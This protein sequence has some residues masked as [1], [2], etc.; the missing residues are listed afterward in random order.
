[1]Q[2]MASWPLSVVL[3]LATLGWAQEGAAQE[4]ATPAAQTPTAALLMIDG[5]IDEQW[6]RYF[7][8]ALR[9]AT[10]AK[11]ATVVVHLTTDGGYLD[12]GLDMVN[13]ALEAHQDPAG[14]QPKLIAYIDN[15]AWSAGAMI[16]YA[17]QEIWLSGVA[18]IGDIG[19]IYQGADGE[20]KYAPEK[21]ESPV[22]AQ[23]RTVA[24]ANHWPT[25]KLVKMTA[26]EQELYRFDLSDGPVF[27]IEDDLGRFLATHK[28]LTKDK[29]VLILGK[30]RLVSYTAKEAVAEGMATG[31]VTDLNELYAKLEIDRT[32]VLDL[33]PTGIE[34][35]SWLLAG[36]APMLASLAMFFVFL[37]FKSPGF[38]IWT[39]CAVACGMGFFICQY[40]QDLASNLELVVILLGLVAIG[41]EIFALPTGGLLGIGGGIAVV[42]GLLLSFMPDELQFSWN[43]DG[44]NRAL[45]SAFMQSALALAVLT[46]A[47]VW[48]IRALPTMRAVN[49][50]A[51]TAE[52][53]ATSAGSLELG[54]TLVGRSAVAR[55]DLRPSGFITVDGQDLAASTEHGTYIGAGTTVE[56]IALRFGEAVVRP[57]SG[58]GT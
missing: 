54:G 13:A 46:G 28:D 53:T 3:L 18:H 57:R 2:A 1:M 38:G 14:S 9:Q 29:G 32:R 48:L 19:V 15:K 5:Q 52:I 33:S 26:R 11:V 30:D 35:A 17:H 50:I 25:A 36:F 49:L 27:V 42:T 12:S 23:L 40:Y 39:V 31:I 47:L 37:E 24:E 10:E 51:A 34:R 8:R 56:I 45:T 43:A 6:A 22:R 20:L 58:A 16:A 4:G 21:F 41:V 7:R 55:S 44:F